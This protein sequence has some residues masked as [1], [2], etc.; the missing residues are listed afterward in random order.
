M[1]RTGEDHNITRQAE[2]NAERT[3][4]KA[5]QD[6]VGAALPQRKRVISAKSLVNLRPAACPN[7]QTQRQV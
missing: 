2:L 7:T 3:V 4:V 5:A 1:A 6:A